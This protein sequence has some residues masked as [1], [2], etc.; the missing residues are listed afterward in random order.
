ML[1]SDDRDAHPI[2]HMIY[3]QKEITFIFLKNDPKKNK[4]IELSMMKKINNNSLL[5][6]IIY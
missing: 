3:H 1:S 4:I 6:Q 5:S 2:H